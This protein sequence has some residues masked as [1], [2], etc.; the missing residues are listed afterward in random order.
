MTKFKIQDKEK[1]WPGIFYSYIK[2]NGIILLQN[3]VNT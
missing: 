3:K 1:G 2:C